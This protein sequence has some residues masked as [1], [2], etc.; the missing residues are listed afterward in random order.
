LFQCS[1][2]IAVRVLLSC[3]DFGGQ[4]GKVVLIH[5]FY[6]LDVS[7]FLNP[8]VLNPFVLGL[9]CQSNEVFAISSQGM[10][11]GDVMVG[12]K[13]EGNEWRALL[14]SYVL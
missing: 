10:G 8:F 14:S 6:S 5:Y 11:T 7:R 13:G 2:P 3:S 1:K 4:H 12:G 9:I